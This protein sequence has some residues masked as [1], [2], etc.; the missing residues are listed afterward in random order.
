MTPFTYLAPATV[1]EALDMLAHHGTEARLIAGG[2]ALVNF[3]KLR[4]IQCPFIIGL[5]RLKQ[6]GTI[7]SDVETHVGALTNLHSIEISPIV[8]QH[9]PLLAEACR[10][11]ATI[12]IRIA[13][14]IGGA[15]SHADPNMDTP[16]ALIALDAR[17]RVRSRRGEREVPAHRFFRGVFESVLE[18]GEMVTEIIIPAQPQ[19]SG[20]SFVKF[21]P[22]SQDDYPTVSVAARI[23]VSNGVITDARI[24]LGAVAPT[25]VRAEAAEL[26]L[27]GTKPSE[28]NFREAAILAAAVVDPIADFRGSAEYKR[29]MAVVHLR[30][31]L[32]AAA[33]RINPRT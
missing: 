29:N 20:A 30:R 9:V 33:A 24:A 10:H 21:L 16:P 17:I 2:T 26:A 1:N 23:A 8:A 11:V 32:T 19:G 15:V 22:A 5:R 6:L 12:R 14:T 25:P 18:P 4:L 28:N 7:S 27:R 3:M 13:A 31:A